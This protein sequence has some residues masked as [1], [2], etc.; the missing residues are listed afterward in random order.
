MPCP[1]KGCAQTIA[2]KLGWSSWL[3]ESFD[4]EGGS[5]NSP[6]EAERVGF[7]IGFMVTKIKEK[8][9]F[10]FYK[11]KRYRYEDELASKKI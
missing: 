1:K 2:F 5:G 6:F 3:D 8:N 7:G 11:S 9:I 4:F 10:Y